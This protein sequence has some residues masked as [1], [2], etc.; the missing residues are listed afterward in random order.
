MDQTHVIL[1]VIRHGGDCRSYLFVGE[2]AHLLFLK[3]LLALPC[4]SSVFVVLLSLGLA[5][6]HAIIWCLV[7]T[8]AWTGLIEQC[9]QLHFGNVVFQMRY[10]SDS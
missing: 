5:V 4:R 3:G 7:L 9:S 2:D 6:F 10:L 8:F 1:L